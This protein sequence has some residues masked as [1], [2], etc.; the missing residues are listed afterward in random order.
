VRNVGYKFV[1]QPIA[2]LADGSSDEDAVARLEASYV[3]LPLQ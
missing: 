2:A 3:D 1:A